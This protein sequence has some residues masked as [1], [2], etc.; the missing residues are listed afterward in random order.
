MKSLQVYTWIVYCLHTVILECRFKWGEDRLEEGEG[1]I[2][3][4]PL[5]K[6]VH[7]FNIQL[8]QYSVTNT[9]TLFNIQLQIHV[10]LTGTEYVSSI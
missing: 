10:Q 5:D 7:L 2:P 3:T 9:C 4:L 8:R 1:K 6:T